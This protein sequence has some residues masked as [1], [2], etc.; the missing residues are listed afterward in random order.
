MFELKKSPVDVWNSWGVILSL[1]FLALSNS[2][3]DSVYI[4]F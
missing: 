1:Y 2:S 4:T 3:H